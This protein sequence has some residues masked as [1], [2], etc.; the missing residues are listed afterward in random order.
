MTI[1]PTFRCLL[2]HSVACGFGDTGLLGYLCAAVG[3]WML[4]KKPAKA[5]YAWLAVGA[6]LQLI[7]GLIRH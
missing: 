6:T 4:T 3:A 7:G 5:G 1:Q 2:H